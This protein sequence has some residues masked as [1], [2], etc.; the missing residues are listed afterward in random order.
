VG[1]HLANP[2]GAAIA[3]RRGDPERAARLLGAAIAIAPVGDADVNARLEEQF[4][5]PARR[6]PNWNDAYTA[7]AQMGFQEAIAYALGGNP[8]SR[9]SG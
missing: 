8:E 3:A 6:T 1:D 4:F 5:A 7:G 2:P 9:R